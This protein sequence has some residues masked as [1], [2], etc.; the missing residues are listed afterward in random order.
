MNHETL[1]IHGGPSARQRSFPDWPQWGNEEEEALVGALR[2]GKWGSTS[3]DE[4]GHLEREFAVF[5]GAEHSVAVVNATMGL[6]TALKAVGVGPGDEVIVPPY[7]FIASASCVLMVGAVPVFAD[8]L[9]ESLLIDPEQV[10]RMIGPRTRA[11]ICVHLGGSC[12]DMDALAD[13]AARHG[14]HL[15]EDSAQAHGVRWRNRGGGTIGDLGVFSFQSSKNVNAGEGGMI[16]ARSQELADRAWSLA[17]VG[18]V[19]NGGWY[20]HESI[21]WNLRMTEFQAA[22]LRVQLRRYPEQ[23]QRREKNAQ[24]LT[25]CLRDVPGVQPLSRDPRVTAH[26]WHLYAL[27]V[28]AQPGARAV[29]QALAAEGI[30]CSTGYVPLNRNQALVREAGALAGAHGYQP[31]ACPVAET[32]ER[33]VVW[34]PQRVLLGD[35]EDM[36]NIAVAMEKVVRGLAA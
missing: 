19:R 22:V 15:I 30:P 23:M 24:L 35:G 9:P 28:P 32:A 5:Q 20:Q 34:L 11:V 27:R 25:E 16:L 18:R 2:S 33:E 8:V 10:E 7:T 3:G 13:I 12:C 17:N 31:S 4:V 21:G 36:E 29:A 14:V 6:A 26:A 1:A